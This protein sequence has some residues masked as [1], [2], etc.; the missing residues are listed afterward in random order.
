VG[1][2]DSAHQLHTESWGLS[3]LLDVSLPFSFPLLVAGDSEVVVAAA[4]ALVV[5]SMSWYLG[6]RL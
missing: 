6:F 3:T 5:R 1:E 2:Q 4:A